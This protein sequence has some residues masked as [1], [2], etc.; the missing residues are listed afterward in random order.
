MRIYIYPRGTRV[1]LRRGK[2]PIDPKLLGRE[3]LVVEVDEYHPGRY[4]VVLDGES[5]IR[6]FSEDE[7]EAVV[8][9]ASPEE[10]GSAGHGSS[11]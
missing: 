5:R 4:G 11:D 1:Q 8:P 7:L 2:F 9:G 6:E 10:A 3:G